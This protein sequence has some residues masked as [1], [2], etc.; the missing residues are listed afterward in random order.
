M[1]QSTGVVV[2][3][4]SKTE[5][6]R[7]L[8]VRAYSNWDFPKGKVDPGETF[9]EAAIR[10]L[11]EET[12][13][14]V[15]ID[16]KLITGLSGL[17]AAP[18]V[19]YGKGSR[20]KTATYFM[21]ARVSPKKPFLPVSPELGRPEND[22]YRWVPISQLSQLMPQRLVPVVNFVIRWTSSLNRRN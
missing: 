2:I 21:G 1:I 4:W 18:P 13:L 17:L 5:E 16:V 20:K 8:C 11:E 10:E 7:A 22:E 12:S 9:S 19:T 15:P 6:P 3:D 14:G